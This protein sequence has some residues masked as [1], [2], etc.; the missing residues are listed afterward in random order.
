MSL[1]VFSLSSH[2]R[3]SISSLP[4]L[5]ALVLVLPVLRNS[6]LRMSCATGVRI[7]WGLEGLEAC[8]TR[9]MR[10]R[11][12]REFGGGWRRRRSEREA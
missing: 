1:S 10:E 4:P 3:R 7:S 2:D 12:R 6:S 8:E 9:T 11:V 5:P